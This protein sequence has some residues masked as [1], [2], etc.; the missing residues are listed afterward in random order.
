[1]KAIFGPAGSMTSVSARRLAA[2]KSRL[3]IIAAVRVRWLTIEP[4]RGRQGEPVWRFEVLGGLVAEEFHAVAALDQ[5]HALGREALQFDR[6]DLGAVLLL[7]A[8]PLRLLVVVELAFDPADGAVEEIDRR[9]EQVLEVGFEA[10]VGQGRDQGVEDVGDGAG[11]GIA[12]R[13]AA[14]GRVRPGRDDSRRA[15]VR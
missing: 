1:M 8:A 5:R 10:G 4:V 9:P 15:A 3:S 2:R 6:A 13:A 12:L 7:L 11:D 14:A